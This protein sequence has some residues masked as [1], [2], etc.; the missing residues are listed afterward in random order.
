MCLLYQHKLQLW[1]RRRRAAAVAT[2]VGG[3]LRRTR[4]AQN[5]CMRMLQYYGGNID[6]SRVREW[7]SEWVSEWVGEGEIESE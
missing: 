2:I 4:L 1:A 3:T 7:A 5:V 6:S